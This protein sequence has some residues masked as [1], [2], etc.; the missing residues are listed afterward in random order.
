MYTL[1]K[2]TLYIVFNFWKITEQIVKQLSFIAR[3]NN[4][5][6]HMH[7]ENFIYSSIDSNIGVE[8][9]QPI[10][11]NRKCQNLDKILCSFLHFVVVKNMSKMA[12]SFKRW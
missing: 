1:N 12:T 7:L 10:N 8:N 11:G 2:F 3:L 9:R 5:Y 6:I 4:F